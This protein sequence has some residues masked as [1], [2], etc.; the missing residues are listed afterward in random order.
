MI[1][2]G[3][4]PNF[5]V[6]LAGQRRSISIIILCA[7]S[8]ASMIALIVAATRPACY[9]VAAI[10][11]RLLCV[12]VAPGI[13]GALFSWEPKT[14]RRP[15]SHTPLAIPN[16]WPPAAAREKLLVVSR[17]SSTLRDFTVRHYAPRLY[18]VVQDRSR[19]ARVPNSKTHSAALGWSFRQYVPRPIVFT[20]VCL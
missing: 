20:A 7:H 10:G 16:P 14:S 13:S 4:H 8:T 11:R 15:W 6:L 17:N 3:H 1:P 9:S 12:Q 5:S 19:P 2:D 18:N